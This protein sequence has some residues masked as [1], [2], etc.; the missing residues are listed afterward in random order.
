M[1]LTDDI[2]QL[3]IKYIGDNLTSDEKTD[4]KL[5]LDESAEHRIF[6]EDLLDR[7]DFIND[8]NQ[9]SL[10]QASDTM[11]WNERLKT[12][13]LETIRTSAIK[14]S[15]IRNL[16]RLLPSAAALISLILGG[17]MYFIVVKKQATPISYRMVLN[18]VEAQNNN[19]EIRLSNGKVLQVS[20]QKGALVSGDKLTYEDGTVLQNE[21]LKEDL[22]AT[23]N[24]PAGTMLKLQLE[25]GSEIT[26]NAKTTLKYPLHFAKNK[27]V[28]EVDGEAYFKIAKNKKVPFQVVSNGQLIEVTG[29]EFNV[30]T[31][32][33][34]QS[35]TTLVEGSINL[36][37]QG[38][39]LQLTPN[40]QALLASGQLSK[41]VVDPANYIAW[42]DNKFY[43][44]ETDLHTALQLIGQWY[45]LQIIYTQPIKETLLYGEIQR[46]KSL[47]A[48][49]K[50]LERSHIKFELIQENGI[51][52]LFVSN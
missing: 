21:S 52:K 46:T 13:T 36:S 31:Y 51:R 20:S 48:V 26:L 32:S 27:R 24:T 7:D 10:L 34:S 22:M 15:P 38:Q 39:T 17:L 19:A 23:V 47:S 29:T 41:K 6:F 5:W 16:K 43:F 42:L 28:V 14:P 40:Q 33:K 44:N 2:K 9:W 25:D 50:I 3:I 49:L 11:N 30:N 45:D 8:L 18:D 1:R 12:K 35:S 37:A 4:L